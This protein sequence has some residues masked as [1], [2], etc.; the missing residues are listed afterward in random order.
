VTAAIDLNCDLGEG[1]GADEALMALVTSANIAC[2]AHAGDAATMRATVRLAVRNGVA[3]GAHPGFADLENFGR[4]ELALS[5]AEIGAL[6]RTQVEALR[7]I[8]AAEGGRVRH[9]K[10][11]GALYNLAARD[12]VVA[13]AVAAAVA[14]IDRGLWL[15]GLSGGHLLAAGRAQGLKVVA[16]VFADRTYLAD[17]SLTPRERRGAVITNAADAVAQV[18][19]MI[20]EGRVRALEGEDVQITADTVC[21]HGDGVDPV[22][23]ALLL[24]RSLEAEG[25]RVVMPL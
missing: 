25:V 21:L 8:A 15:Y 19:R 5:P 1:G 22:G 12:R 24:R 17:G 16:E 18:V 3:I 6:V 13:D 7:A 4:R 20:R 14:Q 2:G 11:H 9:V 23:F 10:P